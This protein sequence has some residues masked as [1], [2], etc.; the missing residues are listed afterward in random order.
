MCPIFADGL[1]IGIER[2]HRR[3]DLV[4]SIFE[5]TGYMTLSL[6]NA[7]ESSGVSVNSIR[8]SGGLATVP[9]ACE[10]RADITGIPV[11]VLAEHETAALG[12]FMVVSQ[13]A[14]RAN[15]LSELAEYAHIERTIKPDPQAH[16]RYRQIYGL[17]GE[18]YT[19]L[20][21]IYRRRADLMQSL[22]LEDRNTV[23]NL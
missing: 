21:S 17:F 19:S 9:Y 4:R 13:M 10:L 2:Y 3:T 7:I 1:Q 6:I 18:V 15:G 14:G 16:E 8:M 11:H 12:A 23:E 20:K 5:S 22:K